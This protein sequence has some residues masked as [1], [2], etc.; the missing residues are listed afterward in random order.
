MITPPIR[1]KQFPEPFYGTATRLRRL[2][3]TR[4]GVT[5]RRRWRLCGKASTEARRQIA[6]T[7]DDLQI[8]LRDRI[9][10]LTGGMGIVNL[11]LLRLIIDI[12]PTYEQRPQ[13]FVAPFRNRT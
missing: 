10:A 1:V 13:L 12:A 2:R 3:M 11:H 7:A 6:P 8:V 4:S 9:A 5:K